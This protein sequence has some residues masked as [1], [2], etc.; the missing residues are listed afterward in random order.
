MIEAGTRMGFERMMIALLNGSQIPAAFDAAQFQMRKVEPERAQARADN[1][2]ERQGNTAVIHIDGPID[3]N[4]SAWDR[5][6]FDATD[7]VDVQ[8]ALKSAANDS[9]IKNIMPMFDSPGGSVNGI[10]ETADL[11]AQISKTKNCFAFINGMCCSA[12]YWLASQCDQIFS[13]PSAQVGSIGVYLAIL[14]ESRALENEG[15]KVETIK[16]GKLK[17]AGA[18]WK[19]LT[20]EER[21]HFQAQVSAIGTSFRA[22]VNSKRPDVDIETMQGQSFFGQDNVS[23]K[24]IDGFVA[25]LDEALAQF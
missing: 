17:A 6:C 16:D 3:K 13:T 12:A 22:A 4:L 2:M 10:A 24:L 19:P 7:I 23:L 18:S 11:I 5:M 25:D 14:D 8:R 15:L 21:A 9:Q 1:I 20:D